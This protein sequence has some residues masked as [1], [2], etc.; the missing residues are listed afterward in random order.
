MGAREH[1]IDELLGRAETRAHL[2]KR[3]TR[4]ERPRPMR[5]TKQPN[6]S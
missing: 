6:E 5:V 1:E 2:L 3:H 4:L